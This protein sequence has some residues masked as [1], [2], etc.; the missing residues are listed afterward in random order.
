MRFSFL[1]DHG[2][3]NITT[4]QLN[5]QHPEPICFSGSGNS[6]LHAALVESSSCAD[7]SRVHV[8]MNNFLQKARD[9]GICVAGVISESPEQTE[10]R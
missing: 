1:I 3:M 8:L 9:R 5:I 6:K 4:R 2:A 7:D 10:V